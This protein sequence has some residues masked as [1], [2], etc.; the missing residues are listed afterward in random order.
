MRHPLHHVYVEN[1]LEET[2]KYYAEEEGELTFEQMVPGKYYRSG[3]DYGICE[4]NQHATNKPK[5]LTYLN[6]C[7]SCIGGNVLL[8]E[9][10]MT[11]RMLAKLKERRDKQIAFVDEMRTW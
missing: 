4:I 5:I 8:F 11:D 9:V 7:G 6:K 2:M 1:V 10:D 3:N